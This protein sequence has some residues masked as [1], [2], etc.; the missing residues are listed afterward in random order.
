M[1]LSQTVGTVSYFTRKLATNSV[2]GDRLVAD[3][4]FSVGEKKHETKS[5]PKF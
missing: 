4:I 1:V 3:V 5:H 2:F